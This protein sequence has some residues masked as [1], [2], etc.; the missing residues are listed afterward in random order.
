MQFNITKIYRAV[1]IFSALVLLLP[2]MVQANEITAAESAELKLNSS[3]VLEKAPALPKS[4]PEDIS[5][6]KVAAAAI[7][8]VPLKSFIVR[9]E[10]PS[11]VKYKGTIKGLAA[12]E[13]DARTKKINMRASASQAYL[14]HLDKTQDT[15]IDTATT[16]LP[17]LKVT[18]RYNVIF[19]GL[20]VVIKANQA[21]ALKNLPGVKQI[22]PD[23][24]VQP[25]TNVSPKFIKANKLWKA[26]GGPNSA[27]E[28]VVIGVLDTGIWPENP[29]FSDPDSSGKTYA[30]PPPSW[31]G[32]R[33]EFG[34]GVPGDDPFI[35]NNKLV[36]AARFM[37][38]YDVLIGLLPG[39]FPTARDDDGHGTHTASTAGGNYGVE[40]NLLDRL[41]YDISGVAP[42]AH[43]S[44]YKCLGESGGFTSDL[45]AGIQQAVLDGVDVINYSISGG[46]QPY[47]DA[48][49]LAF[50]DAYAAGVFVAASAGNSGPDA[51]TVAHRGPWV[52]TVGASITNRL[53]L[54]IL[55]LVAENGDELELTGTTITD[56]IDTLTPVVFPPSGQ[57]Y[58]L[59]PFA[60]GTFD[61]DIVLC[62]E[63][64]PHRRAAKSYH[65]MQGGA[66]GM[67]YYNQA[68]LATDNCFVPSVMLD[69]AAGAELLAF[70][71][72]HASVEG[73]FEG[74]AATEVKG[75]VMANFS[76]RGGPGQS[77]EVS[78]PDVTAPGAHIVAGH[79]PMPSTIAGGPP[80]YLFQSIQGTSMSSPH[81]A[82]AGALLKALNP[83]WTPG[84]IKSALMTTAKVKVKKEDG[85]TKG[86]AFDFG[87]GR[88]D[89][90]KAADPGITF[91]IP[92]IDFIL[93]AD[94]LRHLNYPSLYLPVMP[95]EVTVLR[96]AKSELDKKGKWKVKAKAPKDV[97]ITVPKHIDLPAGGENTFSITVDASTVPLGEV[98]FAE[99]ELKKGKHKAH[100]PITIV[101][102]QPVV[103][104]L[105]A[106]EPSVILRNEETEFTLTI[107]NT[108][109]EDATVHLSDQLPSKLK[110]ISG[111]V[112]GAR[113][114]ANGVEFDGT[115]YAAQPP[116]VEAAVDPLA[117][118]AG[119]FP[120]S[121]FPS[122]IDIGATDE[123]I[124][125]FN[126]PEF[127]FAGE[128]Y[129]QIG[130]VSN[131]Y[132][133]V[134]GG[135]ADDV[136]YINSDLPDPAAP[137]N[138]LCP[139]WTDL[140]PDFGGRVLINVLTDGVNT[141]VV[142]EWEQ[143][144][145]WGDGEINTT[146][147]WIGVDGYEDISFVYG[148]DISDGDSGYLTVGA[149]NRFGNS[150]ATVYFDGVGDPPAP[151][152][153]N[154]P[155]YE[156]DIF[157]T[158][159]TPGETH[160]IT[161]RAEGKKHGKWT[162]CARMTGDIFD[163]VN[164]ACASGETV[165]H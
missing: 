18:N 47:A 19:N 64:G 7:R 66:A 109:F 27:G 107:E 22:Y 45:V 121:T 5:Q 77:L 31:Q 148:P 67:I 63:G 123:S 76:S 93:H 134:G 51:D 152:Y 124:A 131:G 147:V 50:L 143:V 42:R 156:V 39:E 29:S 153:P 141:W 53:F 48:A 146:Q 89:L 162:N 3:F 92:A 149:E 13:V 17:D 79:T 165:K 4:E 61:G 135:S 105:K 112:V 15:F 72:E 142:V 12:P 100:F 60:P 127:V 88:I 81:V 10:D 11:L 33:C 125:N 99:V 8:Q 137:N 6:L 98:R 120:L 78:K 106:A 86:D 128:A 40:A 75:D 20:S 73:T 104:L 95:G 126:I 87:S 140:N 136:D 102:G 103:T 84:Q 122:S 111:S 160:T 1:A 80:G 38:T 82:G 34:S 130:I 59:D 159:G 65:V 49:E 57:E 132:I 68:G 154:P 155:F 115:L 164:A 9:L 36:G 114:V 71:Q 28:G 74:G 110:L 116:I 35:C 14:Q 157:S 85:V 30:A 2:V 21:D 108:S 163:G 43:I 139:F 161:F 32:T 91:D 58:C 133:V 44:A 119:Y 56:G 54:S 41:F 23:R 150:G 52:T 145:N 151:S 94:Q 26:L 46:E 16:Q 138:I 158:P 144:P 69:A 25:D 97:K 117:S 62:A 55:R 24:L 113:E 96:T 37:N 129:N 90:K 83:H 118:P 101:R 70:M